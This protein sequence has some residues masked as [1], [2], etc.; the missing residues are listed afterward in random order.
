[1]MLLVSVKGNSTKQGIKNSACWTSNITE[2]HTII[3][4]YSKKENTYKSRK[5]ECGYDWG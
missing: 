2:A 5:W 1:M 3:I 4:I